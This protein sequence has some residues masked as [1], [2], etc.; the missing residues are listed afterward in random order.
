MSDQL[1]KDEFWNRLDGIT[2]GMFNVEDGRPVPMS[3]YVD[4][5][6]NA[7]WFITAKGTELEDA[8]RG[9]GKDGRFIVAC[10]HGKLYANITGTAHLVEND[11]KREELWN[12]IAGAWFEGDQDDPDV[13]IVRF[14]LATAEAWATDGS[15]GFLYEIAKAHLTDAKPDTGEHGILKFAA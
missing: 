11:A 7:L 9:G 6:A 12:A 4:R 14:D 1:T 3:H 2:A 13:Q 5:D 15:A 8:L 10:R